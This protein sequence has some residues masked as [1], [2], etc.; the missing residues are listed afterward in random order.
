MRRP[1]GFLPL[2]TCNEQNTPTVL[3]LCHEKHS[4]ILLYV[5]KYRRRI[6]AIAPGQHCTKSYNN[7]NP[8]E[9]S[10][11]TEQQSRIPSER[12]AEIYG[13]YWH[14]HL[15]GE[16]ENFTLRGP[17]KEIKRNQLIGPNYVQLI[18]KGNSPCLWLLFEICGHK[19]PGLN[20]VK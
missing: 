14:S 8:L 18:L 7:A 3:Y 12:I 20:I 1:F 10:F 9:G 15:H 2:R 5:V 19:G 16:H 4:L 13:F 6:V 17:F 11:S